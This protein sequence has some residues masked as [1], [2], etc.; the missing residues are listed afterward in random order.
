MQTVRIRS[1]SVQS[2]PGFEGMFGL[3]A[4]GAGLAAVALRRKKPAG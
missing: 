1:P 4:L 2:T 3:L